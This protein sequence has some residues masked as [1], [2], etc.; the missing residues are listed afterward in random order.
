MTQRHYIA[1]L[2][3]ELLIVNSKFEIQN[4]S[5]RLLCYTDNKESLPFC[6]SNCGNFGPK[7]LRKF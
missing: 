4:L 5:N 1:K 7:Y 3:C 6:G 2:I